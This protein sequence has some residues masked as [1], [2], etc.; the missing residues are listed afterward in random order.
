M[1]PRPTAL[2]PQQHFFRKIAVAAA[3]DTFFHRKSS[4]PY[5]MNEKS[6]ILAPRSW[7]SDSGFQILDSR[8]WLPDPGYQILGTRSWLPDPD[9]RIL[10]IYQKAISN[11]GT[12][13]LFVQSEGHKTIKKWSFL[14]S[15]NGF[16]KLSSSS[17]VFRPQNASRSHKKTLFWKLV[18]DL[19]FAGPHFLIEFSYTFPTLKDT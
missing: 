15:K 14:G 16:R 11:I 18:C 1:G 2:Q 10:A 4:F 12:E 7:L 9:S 13:I 8:S 3:R 6:M 5:K 17:C 19:G